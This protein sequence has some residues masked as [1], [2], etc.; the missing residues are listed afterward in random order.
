MKLHVPAATSL[1]ESVERQLEMQNLSGLH[2]GNIDA[3]R[4]IDVYLLVVVE[5]AI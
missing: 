4:R 5:L 2:S 1:L 3:G